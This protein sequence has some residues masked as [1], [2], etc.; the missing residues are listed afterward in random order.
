MT[1][2][3]PRSKGSGNSSNKKKAYK[4]SQAMKRYPWSPEKRKFVLDF[5]L[6][7]R[8]HGTTSFRS[9]TAF[10]LI[11]E[12]FDKRFKPPVTTPQLISLYHNTQAA[13]REF[14]TLKRIKDVIW[15]ETTKS[16]TMPTKF[17][18]EQ[19]LPVLSRAGTLSVVEIGNNTRI[20]FEYLSLMDKLSGD[21]NS[22]ISPNHPFLQ[23]NFS[24]HYTGPRLVSASSQRNLPPAIPHATSN[25]PL[26]NNL[27]SSTRTNNQSHSIIKSE[28]GFINNEIVQIDG[29]SDDDGYYSPSLVIDIED[30]HSPEE[31]QSDRDNNFTRVENADEEQDQ[32]LPN[33]DKLNNPKHLPTEEILVSA[34]KTLKRATAALETIAESTDAFHRSSILFQTQQEKRELIR[35][36]YDLSNTSLEEKGMICDFLEEKDRYTRLA[37]LDPVERL[38]YLETERPNWHRRQIN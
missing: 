24:I 21:V 33:S 31:I 35:F 29:N 19:V 18:K 38:Q 27:Q 17:W 11:K 25:R 36:V 1:T 28:S 20:S 15:S 5:L 2:N 26:K 7:L 12:S 3:S 10:T 22:K 6:S 13:H 14:H 32:E 16:V 37:V 23:P 4:S 8:N 9:S 34:L 30:S